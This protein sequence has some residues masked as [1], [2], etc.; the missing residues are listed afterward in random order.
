MKNKLKYLIKIITKIKNSKKYF[1]FFQ[2]L[3]LTEHFDSTIQLYWHVYEV[4]I[5]IFKIFCMVRFLTF[6]FRNDY[7]TSLFFF[8][9]DWRIDDI[10]NSEWQFPFK[11]DTSLE[12]IPC[13]NPTKNIKFSVYHPG[14]DLSTDF[15]LNRNHCIIRRIWL[16]RLYCFIAD[17]D[18]FQRWLVVCCFLNAKEMLNLFNLSTSQIMWNLL[19]KF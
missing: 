9:K 4:K 5:S 1:F 13:T 8:K 14:F 16:Q 18:R 15:S 3:I 7:K 6:V 19:A 10:V 17:E 12:T 11:F 2:K